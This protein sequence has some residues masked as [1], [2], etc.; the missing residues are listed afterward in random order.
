MTRLPPWRGRLAAIRLARFA[1]VT[2]RR[3]WGHG[4]WARVHWQLRWLT[5]RQQ[6]QR[7]QRI[8]DQAATWQRLFR[9]EVDG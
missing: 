1:G 7:A 4:Y 3:G 6:I 5:T 2:T 9:Q 8:A